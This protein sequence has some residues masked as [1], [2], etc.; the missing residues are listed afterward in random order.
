[1]FYLIRM[2]YS[3]PAAAAQPFHNLV[4]I[5]T[6]PALN[7]NNRPCTN[8]ICFSHDQWVVTAHGQYRRLT[9][10][11]TAVRTLFG[12][13]KQLNYQLGAESNIDTFIY[14]ICDFATMNFLDA[15][16][17]FNDRIGDTVTDS[18]TDIQIEQL[19]T[20]LELS[21]NVD[22]LSI[23]KDEIRSLIYDMRNDLRSE[24]QLISDAIH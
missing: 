11:I 22:C 21:A 5:S 7:E 19:I 16:F 12:R 9:D 20:D 10:A 3:G 15:L 13:E 8:G 1:M 23:P 14:K 2:F 6:S 18:I 24:N 17:R 4:T